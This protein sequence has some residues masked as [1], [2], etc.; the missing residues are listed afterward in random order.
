MKMDR[1][2]HSP[3]YLHTRYLSIAQQALCEQNPTYSSNLASLKS[4]RHEVQHIHSLLHAQEIG[5]LPEFGGK[6][7][8]KRSRDERETEREKQEVD[9]LERELLPWDNELAM[10]AECLV[11]RPKVS[12]IG[13]VGRGVRRTR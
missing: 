5:K 4:L 10:L 1:A 3:P 12:H 6:N 13:S 2:E 9:E 7:K 11:G 8:L